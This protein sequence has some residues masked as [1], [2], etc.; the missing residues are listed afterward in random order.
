MASHRA[1]PHLHCVISQGW[2]MQSGN[3]RSSGRE[4]RRRGET[5]P[6]EPGR[7]SRAERVQRHAGP[8]NIPDWTDPEEPPLLAPMGTM[9]LLSG[10]YACLGILTALVNRGRTGEG[11]HVDAAMYD[12]GAAF[13]ERPLT[14]HEYTGEVPTRGIDRFSPVGAFRAGD[15]G[16][17]SIVIPTEEMWQRCCRA[18]DRPDLLTNPAVDTVLKRAERMQDIV[19]P[20]LEQWAESMSQHEAVETLRSQGQPAGAVQTIEDVRECPQL[21]HRGLF[22]PMD[23]DRLEREDGSYPSLPR[24]PILFDGRVAHPG[25]VPRLGADNDLLDGGSAVN[26]PAS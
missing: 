9:D 15:G 18:M 6:Q 25:I 14:L 12:I 17:I 1:G 3:A 24:L 16:W 20:A 2:S 22:V 19:L 26:D 23:D 8:A 5:G 13:L 21:A 10:V 4:E 11:T 7:G